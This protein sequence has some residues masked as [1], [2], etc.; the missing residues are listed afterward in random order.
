[1]EKETTS[2]QVDRL[3]QNSSVKQDGAASQ[4]DAIKKKRGPIK[5]RSGNKY[6]EA[7]FRALPEEEKIRLANEY[8]L[9]PVKDFDG[10]KMFQFSRHHL[11]DLC[12]EY[13]LM[14]DT[15]YTKKGRLT[16]YYTGNNKLD[17]IP[18]ETVEDSGEK[19]VFYIPS[20]KDIKKTRTR[21]SYYVTLLEDFKKL[22][23]GAPLDAGDISEL[24]NHV[25]E[26]GLKDLLKK[27]E[28]G[29]FEVRRPAIPGR[30]I[31]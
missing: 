3:E 30:R 10:K 17:E 24:I 28:N 27:K 22:Y 23:K 15:I 9:M 12:K 1:M 21:F 31:I 25:L 6:S 8:L 4:G 11:A 2:K 18:A 14:E 5:D 7:D 26:R 16:Y 20:G 29:L 19:V 13:G